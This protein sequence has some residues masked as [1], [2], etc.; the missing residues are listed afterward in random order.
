M[1]GKWCDFFFVIEFDLG[2][3]MLIGV[4]CCCVFGEG[5][6]WDDLIRKVIKLEYKD[7]RNFLM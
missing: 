6:L 1:Y 5:M 4:L 7:K 2:F 3:V